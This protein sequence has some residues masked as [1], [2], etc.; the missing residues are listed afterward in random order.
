MLRDRTHPTHFTVEEAV[1]AAE[2]IGAEST[3]FIHMT[4]DLRHAEL[5]ERLPAGM[6]PAW[7]G[8]KL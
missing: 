3:W 2:R 8:L 7:D 6:A 5:L 1:E 4:H